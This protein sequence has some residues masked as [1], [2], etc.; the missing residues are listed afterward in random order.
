MSKHYQNGRLGEHIAVGIDQSL[1]G[2]AMSFVDVAN[3]ENHVT[4]VWKPPHRGIDRLKEVHQYVHNKMTYYWAFHEID[5]VAMEGTVLHSPSALLLGELSSIVRLALL[6]AF[7]STEQCA[8]PL[9]VPPTVLKKYTTGK[10]NAKKI[11][12]MESVK[13]NWGI[14][15]DDDNAADA[16]SLGRLASGRADTD[17]QKNILEQLKGLKY[18]DKVL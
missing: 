18:R 5:D 4:E 6:Q 8:Y 2:F 11:D 1:T 7:T 14:D 12:M 3:P 16:Y 15:F 9:I 17:I 13:T 10:G